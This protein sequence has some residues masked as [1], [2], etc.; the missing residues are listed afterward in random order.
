MAYHVAV[1]ESQLPRLASMDTEIYDSTKLGIITS[2]PGNHSK[3]KSSITSV[4]VMKGDD[5]T[6]RQVSSL[7]IEEAKQ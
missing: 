6:W 4:G 7:F 3:L 2:T 1:M 5:Q